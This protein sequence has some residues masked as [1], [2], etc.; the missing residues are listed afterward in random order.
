MVGSTQQERKARAKKMLAYLKKAY[1]NPKTEL[2][3]KTPI[4]LVASVML[5]AQS[6]DKRVNF[7]TDTLWKKYKTVSDFAD[8]NL[9][10]FTKEISSITFYRNKAKAIIGT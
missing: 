6:T 4:Q 5:S 7:V 2:T 8:A 1:P 3:Y 10:E 9:A